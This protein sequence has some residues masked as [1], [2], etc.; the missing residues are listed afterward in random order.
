MC[1]IL[2]VSSRNGSLYLVSVRLGMPQQHCS[3]LVTCL[4]IC[5][6]PHYISLWQEPCWKLFLSTVLQCW[7]SHSVFQHLAPT[8]ILRTGQGGSNRQVVAHNLPMSC[9]LR[10]TALV[11]KL[12]FTAAHKFVWEKVM[13]LSYVCFV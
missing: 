1:P 3:S 12:W 8:C 7:L 13:Y 2:G 5:F 10:T 9:N 11:F 4:C 6:V